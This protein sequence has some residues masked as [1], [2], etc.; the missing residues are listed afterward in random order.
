[1]QKCPY[2]LRMGAFSWASL[3]SNQ[4]LTDYESGTLTN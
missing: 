2:T 4:G 3:G 1:M